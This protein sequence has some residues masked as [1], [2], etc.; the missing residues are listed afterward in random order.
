MIE[1]TLTAILR[2]IGSEWGE[3]ILAEAVQMPPGRARN[4]WLWGGVKAMLKEPPMNEL[5][6]VRYGAIMGVAAVVAL[7]ATILL[8]YPHAAGGA[9][10]PI[11]T[12]F[13]AIA[14]TAYVV[15]AWVLTTGAA[16]ATRGR[17]LRVGT[18]A[19]VA[20]AAVLAAGF[21]L[22][23]APSGLLVLAS[24]VAPLLAAIAVPRIETGL[25]TGMT[26]ALLSL[27]TTMALTLAFPSHVPLDE[28]VLRNNHTAADILAANI[29][30]SLVGPIG[31]LVMG[32]LLG[33]LFGF[34]GVNLAQRWRSTQ[35]GS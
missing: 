3:A 32:P 17:A 18:I 22:P 10:G 29:G 27:A 7:T 24:A 23:I 9:G 15:V 14:L 5:R 4:A 25:W 19:G 26:A 8:R 33:L 11:Y 16:P 21:Q 31:F 34:L 30:E 2:W 20:A 13:L 1:A 28:D 35:T 6:T 12:A